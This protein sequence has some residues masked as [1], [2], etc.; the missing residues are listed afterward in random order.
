MPHSDQTVQKR[1]RES[2]E[3]LEFAGR[4]ALHKGLVPHSVRNFAMSMGDA[5]GYSRCELDFGR[6]NNER[7]LAVRGGTA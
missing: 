7:N 6:A 1:K 2:N 4:S 3:Q 5:I